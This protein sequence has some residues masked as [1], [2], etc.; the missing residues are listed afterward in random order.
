MKKFSNT[1]NQLIPLVK[2]KGIF[3]SLTET[4]YKIAIVTLND[5]TYLLILVLK[6]Y[7]K[8]IKI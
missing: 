1:T 6:Q 7:V 3:S 8:N 2:T 5:N 4:I